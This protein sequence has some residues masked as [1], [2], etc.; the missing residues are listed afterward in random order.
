MSGVATMFTKG[1]NILRR[2]SNSKI[3]PVN[4]DD[5]ELV[6]T[7]DGSISY[8]GY[9]KNG[10][11]HGEGT[12]IDSHAH[13]VYTG[14]WQDDNIHGNGKIYNYF[15]DFG[16]VGEFNR[17]EMVYGVMKW[18]DGT[19]YTGYFENNEMSVIGTMLWSNKCKYEG[20]FRDGKIHGYGIY[21]DTKGDIYDGEFENNKMKNT[22]KFR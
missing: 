7:V 2:P 8:E 20:E 10:K 18:K 19:S 13:V 1:I 3:Y 16:F 4:Y 17:N 11:K 9:T 12:Y 15:E 14:E 5:V 22:S 21:I 6:K